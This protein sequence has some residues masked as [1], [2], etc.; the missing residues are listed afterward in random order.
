[1][2]VQCYLCEHEQ[3][4][5]CSKK[6]KRGHLIKIELKKSRTCDVYSEDKFKVLIMFKKKEEHKRRLEVMQR[7]AALAR[8]VEQDIEV[9]QE[10]P[11]GE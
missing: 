8:P 9:R 6:K 5:F 10:G 11:V 7:R 1:M 3:N 2:K 4:G